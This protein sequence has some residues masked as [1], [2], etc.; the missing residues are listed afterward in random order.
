MKRIRSF[1]LMFI[2]VFC[3]AL[4][5]FAAQGIIK[6]GRTLVPVRGVFE[7]LG[8]SVE[9]NGLEGEAVLTDGRHSVS[10]I[11]GQNYIKADGKQ[12]YPDV[13]QQIINN[14][15][16]IP[17]KVIADAIGAETSWD[18]EAKLVHISY[19]GKDSYI[20]CGEEKQAVPVQSG[21][22]VQT[23]KTS[24]AVTAADEKVK[25]Y[26]LNTNTMR[27]HEP[28]CDSVTEMNPRNRM[29]YMGTIEELEKEG[30]IPCGNCH[31]H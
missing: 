8:F 11:K 24:Q 2:I 12:I 21:T 25:T 22:A 18:G 10:I 1:L 23:Q 16:Y 15:F 29:E 4:N 9:W 30:Y 19:S 31:P 28:G 14:G 6:D 20:S 27:I 5:V 3:S 17:V 7:E 26:V 13:P